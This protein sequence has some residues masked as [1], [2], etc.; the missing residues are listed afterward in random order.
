MREFAAEVELDLGIRSAHKATEN[1][2]IATKA[3]H[4]RGVKQFA[5]AGN[6]VKGC[7]TDLLNPAYA[8]V[9]AYGTR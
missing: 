5:S 6:P 2:L 7:Q 8:L 9:G 4:R 1:R 3:N